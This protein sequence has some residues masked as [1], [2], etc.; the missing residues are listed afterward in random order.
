[1]ACNLRSADQ[2]LR[3]HHLSHD[4]ESRYFDWTMLPLTKIDQSRAVNPRF[5]TN[6]S[7]SASP[8]DWFDL[9]ADIRGHMLALRAS[10]GAT[11]AEDLQTLIDEWLVSHNTCDVRAAGQAARFAPME[12]L[13]TQRATVASALLSNESPQLRAIGVAVAL[14]DDPCIAI[15]HLVRRVEQSGRSYALELAIALRKDASEDSREA[16][17]H[18]TRHPSAAVRRE[19]GLALQAHETPTGA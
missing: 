10:L 14:R 15:R 3:V 1:M 17:R 16:L 2:L 4:A 13:G 11:S 5:A 19:A 8:P 18:L 9:G 7:P 6:R 12:A